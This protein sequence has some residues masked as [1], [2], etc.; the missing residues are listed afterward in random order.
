MIYMARN[1]QLPHNVISSGCW[2]TTGPQAAGVCLSYNNGHVFAHRRQFFWLLISKAHIAVVQALHC[3]NNRCCYKPTDGVVFV[4][5]YDVLRKNADTRCD[6]KD[7]IFRSLVP[8][9]SACSFALYLPPV[10]GH[11][12][13]CIVVYC[14]CWTHHGTVAFLN[15]VKNG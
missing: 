15:T 14:V 2:F 1:Q 8:Q 3:M 11:P 12:H 4:T 5:E 9:L 10:R 7:D 13:V 6:I